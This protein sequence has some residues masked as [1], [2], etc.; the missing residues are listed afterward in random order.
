MKL[1][2]VGAMGAYFQD[3]GLRGTL[4]NFFLSYDTE[5]FNY[6]AYMTQTMGKTIPFRYGSR[7]NR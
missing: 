6:V 3:V 5:M 4:N 2:L 7:H 1:D